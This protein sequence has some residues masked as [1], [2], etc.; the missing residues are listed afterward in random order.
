MP[1][2]GTQTIMGSCPITAWC[3]ALHFHARSH[4]DDVALPLPPHH[5]EQH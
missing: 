1:C 5:N 4:N 3:C 2:E